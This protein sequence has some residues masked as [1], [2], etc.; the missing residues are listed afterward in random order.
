MQASPHSALQIQP[1]V[2]DGEGCWRRQGRQQ[3]RLPGPAA[4]FLTSSQKSNRPGQGQDAPLG[5]EDGG[6]AGEGTGDNVW[7]VEGG[8]EAAGAQRGPRLFRWGGGEF[9]GLFEFILF[10]R[11]EE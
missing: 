10:I 7:Q 8:R 9:Q 11:K 4:R 1:D 3:G 2:C 6:E 5:S